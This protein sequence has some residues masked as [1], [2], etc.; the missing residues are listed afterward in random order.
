LKTAEPMIR[1]GFQTAYGR[2][3]GLEDN[4]RGI[5]HTKAG[6]VTRLTHAALNPRETLMKLRP[7]LAER[8]ANDQYLPAGSSSLLPPPTVYPGKP[9]TVTADELS[10]LGLDIGPKPYALPP[11][12]PQG[13]PALNQAPTYVPSPQV[14]QAFGQ[15]ALPTA[16]EY[17]PMAAMDPRNRNPLQETPQGSPGLEG[18]MPADVIAARQAEARATRDAVARQSRPVRMLLQPPEQPGGVQVLTPT[19]LTLPRRVPKGNVQPNGYPANLES[20]AV[21]KVLNES[22]RRP[23]ILNQA[24]IDR[25]ME[26]LKRVKTKESR[27]KLQALLREENY[28]FTKGKQ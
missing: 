6:V 15:P 11:R 20:P 2:A 14:P 18:M 24:R 1:E 25:L 28:R 27:D 8:I 16:A 7:D 9:P 26:A 3:T 10:A 22:G 21:Q 17:D 13:R 19:E 23:I 5:P 4:S 12:A